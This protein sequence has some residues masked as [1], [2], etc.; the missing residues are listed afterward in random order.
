L[1]S[2]VW[3]VSPQNNSWDRLASFIGRYARL[4]FDGSGIDCRL[5]GAEVIP[6]RPLDLEAQHEVL[7]VCKEAM[8]NVLK[9]SKAT[10]VTL[11]FSLAGDVFEV[12]VRD[13]GTGF[14]PSLKEHAER[15]GLNN[16]RTRAAELK[17]C[18]TIESHASA[19]TLLAL[20]VPVS[21]CSDQ[22]PEKII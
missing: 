16:M 21:K 14:E 9:H 5:E 8:N 19:G 17:G 10:T 3:T 13:N 20:R 6:A 18:L 7:A 11:R 12:S 1:E 22:P 2:I 15:N 4:F